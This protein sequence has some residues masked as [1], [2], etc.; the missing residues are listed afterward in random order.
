MARR[1]SR[2]VDDQNET[3]EEV[4]RRETKE[5]IFVDMQNLNKVA[6]LSFYFPHNSAKIYARKISP[7]D[8]LMRPLIIIIDTTALALAGGR[9]DFLTSSSFSIGSRRSE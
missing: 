3:I 2:K 7:P 5:E 6:E 1:Q 8:S 4:A 9:P